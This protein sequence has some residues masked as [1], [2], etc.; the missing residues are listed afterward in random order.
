MRGSVIHPNVHS[1]GSPMSEA[2]SSTGGTSVGERYRVLLGIS[3]NLARTLSLTDLYRSTYKETAR[4]LEAG[5]F[6]VALYDRTKD[7]ATVVFYADRGAEQDLEATYK[8]SESEV[9]RTGKGCLVRD[10]LE[11]RS[12]MVLGEA[13][14]E[15]TRSAITVP[16]LYEGE[17]IGAMSTQSYQPDAFDEEDLELLQGIADLAAVAIT[18]ARHVAQLEARRREAERIEEIGRAITSSLDAKEVLRA[19]ID[20]VLELLQADASSVWLLEGTHARVA[21]SGGRIRVPEGASWPMTET[22]YEAMV[23]S[24]RPVIVEDLSRSQLLSPEIHG[25]S[26]AGSAILVPLVLDDEVAGGLSATKIARR[27]VAQEDVEILLRLAGQT[28]VA[29][30]NA[31]LHESIQALSL[32]DPLTD[33]PNR[34]HLDIHLR[35]EVAAARRG[36]PVCF[37]LFDLDDFK[38]HNDR[39]GHVVGD[40]ILRSFGRILRSETRAMNMAARYGGDEFVSVLTDISREGAESHAQ[41]V[42]NRVAAHPELARYGVSVSVGIGEFDPVRMFEV[43]DLVRA[44]DQDL[45]RSK[46]SR[47]QAP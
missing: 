20:A 18:N 26:Q 13:G 4:V 39:L 17:V 29:L 36:R 16:L 3:H 47:G 8:G 6:Y 11:T 41:R 24:R 46:L 14:T 12:L 10:R 7:L 19:V 44:A 15:L 43:E 30:A 1:R 45:Y 40:Q 25:K 28:S 34:R 27:A 31:R 21:S 33:L 2:I 22:L 42:A 23:V 38:L 37:I 9:L 35:R 32:T 5:G